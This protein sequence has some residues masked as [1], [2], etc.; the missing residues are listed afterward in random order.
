M[1]FG[2]MAYSELSEAPGDNPL[3]NEFQR[4]C[5]PKKLKTGDGCPARLARRQPTHR[6]RKSASLVLALASSQ[7]QK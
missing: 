7:L 4:S 2:C 1:P 5:K 6:H 3:A